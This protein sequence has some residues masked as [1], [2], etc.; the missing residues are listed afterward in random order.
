M[1]PTVT[2]APPTPQPKPAASLAPATPSSRASLKVSKSKKSLI[3]GLALT[4]KSPPVKDPKKKKEIQWG[5]DL[6]T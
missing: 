2:P 6:R 1:E 4:S 3:S 5:L